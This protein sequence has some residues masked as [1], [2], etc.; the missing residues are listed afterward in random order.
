MAL[1]RWH[2]T[3]FTATPIRKIDDDTWLMRSQQHTARTAVGTEI[4]VK[5]NEVVEM[6]AAEMPAT[7]GAADLEAAMAAERETL[8]PVKELLKK[9]ADIKHDAPNKVE[10]KVDG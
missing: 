3:T 9:G 4:K 8:T 10:D 1:V 2:G 6:G 5:R 7:D